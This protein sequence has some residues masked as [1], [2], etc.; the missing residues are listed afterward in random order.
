[1]LVLPSEEAGVVDAMIK[2]VQPARNLHDQLR[3]TIDGQAQD[4]V[5]YLTPFD[6]SQYV[7]H[8]HTRTGDE[9]IEEVIPHAQCLASQLFL[10]VRA[11]GRWRSWCTA[12]D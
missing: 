11:S 3:N 1:M 8:D 7:F 12:A 9:V 10:A 6:P 4:I 5:D 2:A